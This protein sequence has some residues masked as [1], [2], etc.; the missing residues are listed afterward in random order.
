MYYPS[1]FFTTFYEIMNKIKTAHQR[2]RHIKEDSKD[3]TKNTSLLSQNF[4]F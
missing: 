1:F 2:E 4:T 3:A